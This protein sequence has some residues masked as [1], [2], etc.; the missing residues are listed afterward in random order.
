M[1]FADFEE[2]LH[3][4]AAEAFP[5]VKVCGESFHFMQANLHWMAQHVGKQHQDELAPNLCQLMAS[6]E[7]NDTLP[8]V[9]LF[10][11]YWM[12]QCPAYAEYFCSMWCQRWPPHLWAAFGHKGLKDLP[13]GDHIL[14]GW[15]NCLQCHT[16]PKH[17]KAI[18]HAVSHLWDERD[19]HHHRLASP[20]HVAALEKE[21]VSDAWKWH[22]QA[23]S[24]AVHPPPVPAVG[25]SFTLAIDDLIPT[26][27]ESESSEM[28]NGVQSLPVPSGMCAGCGQ[29]KANIQCVLQACL[30]CCTKNITT[31]CHVMKHQA[32]KV[33]ILGHPLLEELEKQFALPQAEQQALFLWY[34]GG[35]KPGT[36]RSITPIRWAA[37]H[38][39]FYAVADD[40]RTEK[41]YILT[42][43]AEWRHTFWIPT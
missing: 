16:W 7:L 24:C 29:T 19:E 3:N 11:V 2:A 23:E 10:L 25:S 41:K 13:S 4:A 33:A 17:H 9:K 36:V 14:E 12:Q 18:D 37:R 27:G 21:K 8:Q 35:S 6:P 28:V 32:G 26:P 1:L 30:K 34:M 40:D 20:S 38:S 39:S 22:K 31:N 5:G 43:V 42:C 15:H